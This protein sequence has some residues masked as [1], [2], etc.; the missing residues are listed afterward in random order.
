MAGL[1]LV[2][3][4]G[5]RAD[6]RRPDELRK[7]RARLGVLARADGSAYLEQGNTKVLAAVYGPPVLVAPVALP[8]SP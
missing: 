7:V 8:L 2:S 1:E 4:A 6:G 5:F 3:D